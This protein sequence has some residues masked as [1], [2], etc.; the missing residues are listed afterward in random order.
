MSS[1]CVGQ[2]L[3]GMRPTPREFVCPVRLHWRELIFFLCKWLS[4]GDSFLVRDGSPCPLPPLSDGTP[5]GLDLC[6]PRACCHSL[7]AFISASVLLCLEDFPWSH[8]SPLALF[9]FLSPLLQSSLSPEEKCLMKTSHLGLSV[10]KSL[11]LC[12]LSSCGSHTS[13]HLLQ[14]SSLMMDEQDV[15]L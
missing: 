9:I 2:L 1:F 7:C 12:E 15:D 10:P 4:G 5:S 11:S 3:L 8:L 14:E 6:R 13:S